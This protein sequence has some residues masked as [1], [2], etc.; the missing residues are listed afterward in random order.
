MPMFADGFGA[1]EAEYLLRLGSVP[2]NFD[3]AWTNEEAAAHVAAT[4]GH[5]F[6]AYVGERLMTK[7][8]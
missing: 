7:F 4:V 3:R 1:A 2:E 8:M 5:K 6:F